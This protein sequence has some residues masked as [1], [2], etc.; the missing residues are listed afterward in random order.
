MYSS[1]FLVGLV[2]SLVGFISV[3]RP[4]KF[5]KI[6]SRIMGIVILVAGLVIGATG[7]LLISDD[8]VAEK[9]VIAAGYLSLANY[10]EAIKA[11]EDEMAA[12]RVTAETEALARGENPETLLIL[13]MERRKACKGD[14]SKCETHKE[15][16]TINVRIY[17]AGLDCKKAAEK[18][19]KNGVFKLPFVPFQEFYPDPRFYQTGKLTLVEPAAKYRNKA[20]TEQRVMMI[21]QYDLRSKS[22]V[23]LDIE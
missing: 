2:I 13:E 6:K 14:W 19:A 17:V 22:V 23:A 21:C 1:L 4:L 18:R 12:A 3:I 9:A 7:T 10:N 8:I 20:G 15:L 16:L 11:A 5:L